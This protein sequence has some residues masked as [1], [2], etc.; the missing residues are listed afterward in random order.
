[1]LLHLLG[2]LDLGSS[3]TLL[4]IFLLFA[5]SKPMQAHK[6][7][8]NEPSHKPNGFLKCA[9][10]GPGRS[11]TAVQN[12]FLSTSYSNILQYIFTPR[13]VSTYF[14]TG[15]QAPEIFCF[16]SLYSSLAAAN[17][18]S[19]SCLVLYLANSLCSETAPSTVNDNTQIIVE[20]INLLIVDQAEIE[21]ATG[22]L[23]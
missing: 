3:P 21:P 23:F 16:L 9:F 2:L 7:H 14:N 19:H 1:M 18:C 20:F 10:G 11:R 22:T 13:R 5:L 8:T 6:K 12:A 4:S 17:A 15:L